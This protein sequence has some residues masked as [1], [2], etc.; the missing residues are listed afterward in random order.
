MGFD[1]SR[2]TALSPDLARYGIVHFATHGVFDDEHP[3]QS[4]IVLSLF[5]PQGRSQDGFLR[6]HD[7]YGLDLPA[8]MVVLS[9]CDTALGEQIRGEGLVGMVRGFMHAGAERVV[10]TL[11]RV[12]DEATGEVMGHFYREM[13]ENGLSPAAALRQAQLSVRD[14]RRWRSPFYW[15]A[16]TL[17]GE[18]RQ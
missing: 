6:L 13:F 7:I 2:A 12:D 9:A 8:R 18:W 16:F 10:A 17:Q 5:D 4:G 11:W 15:A 1:A 14:Q 3:G